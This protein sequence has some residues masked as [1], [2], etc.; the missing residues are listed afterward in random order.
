MSGANKYTVHTR[1]AMAENAIAELKKENAE[2]RVHL[3][4]KLETLVNDAKNVIQ[5]SIRVPQD[6]KDG[7]D[8]VDGAT[9][10]QGIQ[11][12][13]GDVLVVGETEC[14][15]AVIALRRKLV[16]Q[17]AAVL[18]RLTQ[19]IYTLGKPEHQ[20]TTYRLLRSHLERVKKD[21]EKLV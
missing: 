7:R 11:G 14:A 5:D 8:G 17:H 6:G 12:R 2:L 3:A 16:E 15:R 9:G 19:D 4:G 18:G 21:L 10:P 20:N 13:A 1:L